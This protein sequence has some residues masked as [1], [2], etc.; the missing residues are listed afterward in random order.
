MRDYG[1]ISTTL[2]NSR[3][4]SNVGDDGK[5]LYLYLHTCPSVNSIG[6]FIMKDGYAMADLGW[7]LKRYRKAMDTLC[8]AYMVSFDPTEKVVRLVNFLNFDPLTNPKHAQ[9]SAK[10][11]LSLPDGHE[12]LCVL[13]DIQS[14]KHMKE[15]EILEAEISRLSIGYANP[16]ETQNQNQNQNP[17]KKLPS[18]ASPKTPENNTNENGSP[19]STGD[20]TEKAFSLFNAMAKIN[21]W[22]Q[23]QKLTSARKS[24]MRARLKDCGGS[25]G[26]ATALR[27]A[28]QSKFLTGSTRE[29][30]KLTIDFLLRESSFAKLMEGNYDDHRETGKPGTG[31]AADETIA[32]IARLSADR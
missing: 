23:V 6:C 18:V 2:W 5:L 15:T 8:V 30:F 29:H 28:E 1:K 16:I 26:W 14:S 9:G 32:R 17:Y 4:F 24:K 20:E 27:K 7:E 10:R 31:A 22:P 25:E 13:K 3:K 11:A 21:G 12:K 19:A